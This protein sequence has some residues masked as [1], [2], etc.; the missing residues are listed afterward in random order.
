MSHAHLEQASVAKGLVKFKLGVRALVLPVNK[1]TYSYAM[2]LQYVNLEAVVGHAVGTVVW[3]VQ[4]CL[5]RA[6]KQQVCGANSCDRLMRSFCNNPS[7]QGSFQASKQG[8]R[9]VLAYREVQPIIRSEQYAGSTCMNTKV[10]E[11]S[12]LT[13]SQSCTGN[14]GNLC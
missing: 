9:T 8:V 7:E 12:L 6:L 13:F 3:L 10:A 11:C 4:Q 2:Q 5:S 1:R 14:M